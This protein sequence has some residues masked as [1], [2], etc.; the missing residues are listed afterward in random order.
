[1]FSYPLHS[2]CLLLRLDTTSLSGESLTENGAGF[3]SLPSFPCPAHFHIFCERTWRLLLNPTVPPQVSDF[4]FQPFFPIFCRVS[5]ILLT[6]PRNLS[7]LLRIWT[8][9]SPASLPL[10]PRSILPRC[11]KKNSFRL[12]SDGRRE[13]FIRFS[14]SF[15]RWTAWIS[16]HS[17]NLGAG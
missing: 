14:P 11:A 3:T 5:S 2:W 7:F 16:A 4:S 1:M 8:L 9:A 13:P 15:L 10:S 12:H 17:T 6:H